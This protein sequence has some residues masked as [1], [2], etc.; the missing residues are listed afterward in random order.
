MGVPLII[1]V[2]MLCVL[3]HG[4]IIA[5]VVSS[6]GLHGSRSHIRRGQRRYMLDELV[7]DLARNRFGLLHRRAAVHGYIELGR[8]SMPEPADAHAE[9][10]RHLRNMPDCVSDISH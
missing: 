8:Q 5:V 7:F 9:N 3:T 10:L 6:R 1:S 2:G 4:L